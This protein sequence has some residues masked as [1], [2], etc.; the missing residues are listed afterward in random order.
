MVPGD[1]PVQPPWWASPGNRPSLTHD[2][3]WKVHGAVLTHHPFPCACLGGQLEVP[4][5]QLETVVGGAMPG[6]EH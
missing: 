3:S 5:G 6:M 2:H 1:E 4:L